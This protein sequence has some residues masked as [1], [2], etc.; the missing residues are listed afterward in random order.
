MKKLLILLIGLVVMANFGEIKAQPLLDP[1]DPAKFVTFSARLGF[2]TS[3]RTFPSG[4]YNLWNKDSWGTGINVGGMANLNFKEYL[5][6]QPG[7]FLESRSG[8]Y[9]YLT[10]YLDFFE[11]G[12]NYYE[13]GHLSSFCVTVPVMGVF[14]LNIAEKIKCT[15]ELGPY[16]QFIVSEKGQNNVTV[17]YRLPSS[18]GYSQYKAQQRKYD[19]GVKMG[20]GLL[21]Y[22]H[23]YIG[24]HY[25]AGACNAWTLPSGGKNKSWM[26]TIGYEI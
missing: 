13:M 10:E 17:L 21:F 2:N 6:V 9:A 16:F 4:H 14:K 25:L 20:G 11:A 26:F 3:N 23:Y 24:V 7:I 8:D 22:D 1:S 15:A 5:T 12:D 19:I 18:T